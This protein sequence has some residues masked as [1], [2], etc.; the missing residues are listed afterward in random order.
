MKSK[1]IC[2][3]GWPE[4]DVKVLVTSDPNARLP[5][6]DKQYITDVVINNFPLFPC[7]CISVILATDL[8]YPSCSRV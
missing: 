7:F 1:T 2:R 6:T 8:V 5:S 3:N 4:E